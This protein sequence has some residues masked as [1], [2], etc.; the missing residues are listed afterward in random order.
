MLYAGITRAS[1]IGNG[2]GG[3]NQQ[4]SHRLG[5]LVRFLKSVDPSETTRRALKVRLMSKSYLL[6]ALHDGFEAKHTYRIAQ[7][8]ESYVRDLAEMIHRLGY[9]AWVY[10]EGAN[11]NVYIVE[12][13]KSVLS[14][15]EISSNQDK[16]DYIR[17]YFDAEGSVP[18]NG[19]RMYIYFCQKDR[20]DLE[21]VK[22]FL[23][24][25]G[26][27]CVKIHNPSQEKDSDYWRFFLSCKSY[28][29]FAKKIGSRHPVK[30]NILKMV[31]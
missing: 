8:Y 1:R 9:R 10:K 20:K 3:V 19:S 6:G 29:D 16:I 28:S 26:I 7:K 30:Q 24:E 22:A 2:S 11:R 18:L 15:F 5:A 23:E 17:G 4:G 21:E 31:I 14:G 25:L 27:I 12:F 13:S